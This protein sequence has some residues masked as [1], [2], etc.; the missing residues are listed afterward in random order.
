MLPKQ[1]EF[2]HHLF[3]AVFYLYKVNPRRQRNMIGIF[4][5]PPS[6]E[7]G[8]GGLMEVQLLYGL[9]QYVKN[10]PGDFGLY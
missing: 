2:V 5:L 1:Q 4:T 3:A 9:P 7:T 6:F 10:V 8:R